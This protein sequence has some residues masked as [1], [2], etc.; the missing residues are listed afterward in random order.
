L[1]YS[2]YVANLG[3]GKEGGGRREEGGGRRAEDS[4][5]RNRGEQRQGET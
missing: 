1:L 4:P 3:E 2:F 5:L